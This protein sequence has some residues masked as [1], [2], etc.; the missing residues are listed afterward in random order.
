[1]RE[2]RPLLHNNTPLHI[3]N[4]DIGVTLRQ[5]A[6][7]TTIAE[8]T[9]ASGRN[10]LRRPTPLWSVEMVDRQSR[11]AAVDPRGIHPRITQDEKT[12][13]L[14][15]DDLPIAGTDATVCVGVTIC[16]GEMGVFEWRLSVE[17]VPADWAVA[18]IGFPSLDLAVDA[19]D[20]TK[21]VL[22]NDAGV[23]YPNPLETMPVGGIHEK[24][25]RRPY[26]H[27]GFTMQ[28]FALE[29][30]G[31][32]L[33]V[34]AHDPTPV[35][36]TFFL[37]PDR[38][39][40]LIRFA[41][42][43]ETTLR[44]GADYE[45]GYPW[46]TRLTRGDWFDAAQTY[47]RF[48]VGASWTSKGPIVN[49]R[50]TPA[51]YQR[52]G[53]VALRLQRGPGFDADDQ[54]A[55]REYLGLP[56]VSHYYMWH[57]AAFDAEYPFLF[58]A[59]PGF[60]AARRKLEAAGVTV[61][62]YFNPYSCDMET[63]MWPQ[64][65]DRM[66]CRIND[67]GDIHAHLWSQNRRFAAMCPSSPLWRQLVTQP[68]M[69]LLEQGCRA[70]YF[71]EVAMSPP[72]ACH[73]ANH[74]HTAGA[75]ST[76][77][78]GQRALAESIR[79]EA[80]DWI[81]DL[82]MT[83]EGA[84]EPYMDQYDAFLIGNNNS[85]YSVPLFSAVYHDYVMGF[86]RY[87]FT[88]ELIDPNF[89]GAIVSKHAQQF[90]WGFQFGWSRVPMSAI[91]EKA[92]HVAAFLR[93]LAHTWHHNADFMAT[94]RMLRPLDLSDQFKPMALRWAR[95]WQDEV[96]EPVSLPPVLNG[97]WRRE[98]GSIA[99]VLVNI[100]E[101]PIDLDVVMPNVQ[102]I[103]KLNKADDAPVEFDDATLSRL[104]PL[105]QCCVAQQ[106]YVDDDRLRIDVAEGDSDNGYRVSL[107]PL[108]CKALVIGSE[109][110]ADVHT[111]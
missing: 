29:C 15:W 37:E 99:V 66:A 103:F 80:G 5:E 59:M 95:S 67:Q 49:G 21:L 58:P 19:T 54:L 89:A 111:G 92:P 108:R 110:Q 20:T 45:Q 105:P 6:A 16:Y 73:D 55:D 13:R 52:T 34:G 25:R 36:K 46:V 107:P 93:H 104:Y 33:Y 11:H 30:D 26:P 86:G 96:G 71:D 28:F 94:G 12:C 2:P 4:D 44:F 72:H 63:P 70:V 62:P 14:T 69:R 35:S 106:R 98:D 1:M 51:W 75:G 50:K 65:L 24:L 10:L 3:R 56:F 78:A 84:A 87:T 32:L 88:H 64:G 100:T 77:V 43:A 8:L 9:D 40:K 102:S 82:V 85:P 60:R 97:V 39:H 90:T 79:D 18:K 57:R 27:G 41:P 109:K 91:R 47:R 38:D 53:L 61:M 23:S 7:G 48:A 83:T 42:S 31:Q 22:P 17:S 68:A 74:G 76:F 101:H 81:D